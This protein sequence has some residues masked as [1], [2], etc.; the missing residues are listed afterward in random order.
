MWIH[1]EEGKRR[2]TDCALRAVR[3]T[4][5]SVNATSIR[6]GEFVKV[7][8]AGVSL[9]DIVPMR[10]AFFDGGLPMALS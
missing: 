8:W 4:S 10:V 6:S 5:I 9:D 1:D 7:S 3:G 2:P